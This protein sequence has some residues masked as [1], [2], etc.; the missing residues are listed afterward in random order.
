M[1]LKGRRLS[2]NMPRL[3]CSL[4]VNYFNKEYINYVNTRTRG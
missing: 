3:V 1:W 2:L 4:K